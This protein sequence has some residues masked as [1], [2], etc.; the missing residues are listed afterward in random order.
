MIFWNL[1]TKQ[2]AEDD[3]ALDLVFSNI[4]RQL[5]MSDAMEIADQIDGG[6]PAVK[7]AAE[8]HQKTIMPDL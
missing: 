7:K 3:D 5:T 4:K 8:K 2:H 6:M 1:K